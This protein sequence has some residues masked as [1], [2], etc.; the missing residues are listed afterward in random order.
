MAKSKPTFRIRTFGTYTQWD[1]ESRDLP[2]ALENT[3][4]IPGVVDVEF[5]FIVNVK[6]G[7]NEKLTFCID[8]PQIKDADGSIRPPFTGEVYVK[9]ND[10]NFFLG[11]T[12]WEPV[13]DKL[14]HWHLSV[15][16]N[17]AVVAEK[18]FLILAAPSP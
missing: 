14:G 15:T 3:T 9:S 6:S 11:D 1:A 10:W 2:R 4:R 12:I 16:W 18:T 8:H 17:G 5:G 7:K 13:H